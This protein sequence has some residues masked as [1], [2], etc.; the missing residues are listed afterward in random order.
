M[1][2][3]IDIKLATSPNDISAVSNL[4][5]GISSLASTLDK[6]DDAARHT[7][8]LK[9][10]TLV[11]ALETPGETMIK[12]TWAQPG[13][14][15][16]LISGVDTGLWTIMAKHVD[17]PQKVNDLADSLDMEPLLLVP[18]LTS[19][20]GWLSGSVAQGA[21]RS[22]F[23]NSRDITMGATLLIPQTIP[24]QMAYGN[25]QNCFEY[26]RSIG[27]GQQVN[28][29]MGGYR[30]GRLP[31]IH[32]SIYPV[33]TTILAGADTSPDTTLI[34][35]VAGG[36]GHDISEFQRMYPNHPGKFVLQDLPVVIADAEKTIDP[37][38]ECMGHDFLAEQPIKGAR[39]YFMH[40]IMHDW[41]D[42]VC[43]NILERLAEAM[44][45]G[46][47]KLLIFDCVIP[48]TGAYWENT[49]GDTLMMTQL[50]ALER[51]E[52][53]WYDLIERSG[54]G[55]RIVKIWRCNQSDVEN[56]IECEPV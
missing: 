48:R 35:D 1:R 36:L 24:L 34:V 8:L 6:N 29:H 32:P 11:Q 51:T 33:E 4:A 18:E 46:Y 17:E 9:A 27:Y 52:E 38:I 54:L 30:Q 31:W 3:Q 22:S 53:N 5:A 2:D 15:A 10:R 25:E 7:L 16:G 13:V 37:R 43:Q 19:D 28:N 21:V 56:L 44:K 47:S 40:S 39:A 55:L 20:W 50:C 45:P 12:H 42:N 26:L 49:A 14:A 41:P 23:T